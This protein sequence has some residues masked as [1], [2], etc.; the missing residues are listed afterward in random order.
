MQKDSCEKRSLKPKKTSRKF[1]KI[2][3]TSLFGTQDNTDEVIGSV[4][5][6]KATSLND[7]LT[8]DEK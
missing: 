1:T 3:N 8:T 2:K 7:E 6:N 4:E 5:P